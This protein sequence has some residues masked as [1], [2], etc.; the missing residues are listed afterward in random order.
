MPWTSAGP[1]RSHGA[2]FAVPTHQPLSARCFVRMWAC[3]RDERSVIRVLGRPVSLTGD[4]EGRMPSLQG[5]DRPPT[6]GGLALMGAALTSCSAASSS[7]GRPDSHGCGSRRQ[8]AHQPSR[9]PPA[10]DPITPPCGGVGAARAKPAVAAVGGAR[11]PPM[12]GVQHPTRSRSPPP[13]VGEGQ[14][15]GF[16]ILPLD[17]IL[18]PS[19]LRGRGRERGIGFQFFRSTPSL[20]PLPSVGEGRERGM[21]FNSSV[22]FP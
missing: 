16:S 8:H 18:S 12:P 15:D 9:T 22:H 11:R 17:S 13:A 1:P 6:R 5:G 3:K 20:A 2:G 10:V 14:G 21:P 19:P 7:A 4:N